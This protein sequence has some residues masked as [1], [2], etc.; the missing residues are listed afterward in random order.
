[1]H[2]PLS[3]CKHLILLPT[4][5]GRRM[6]KLLLYSVEEIKGFLFKTLLYPIDEE[7]TFYRLLWK[8]KESRRQHSRERLFGEMCLHIQNVQDRHAHEHSVSGA[9]SSGYAGT[10]FAEMEYLKRAIES[11]E[12]ER[13]ETIADRFLNESHFRI[14]LAELE[15]IKGIWRIEIF[16]NYLLEVALS[17]KCLWELEAKAEGRLKD[18]SMELGTAKRYLAEQDW[19]LHMSWL[20]DFILWNIFDSLILLAKTT[21]V[22]KSSS[23]RFRR[24]RHA[25]SWLPNLILFRDE[26]D[27]GNYDAREW[28]RRLRHEEDV[29]GTYVIP[30]LVYPLL[31]LQMTKAEGEAAKP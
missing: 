15:G 11:Q 12:V 6:G 20:T 25:V 28:D 31:E 27:S 14:F 2:G 8:L 30:S 10:L 29:T 19:G 16:E 18:E 21:I 7:A 24:M 26:I 13:F 1:M 5:D 4:D 22:D 9:G 3:D 17:R 23:V